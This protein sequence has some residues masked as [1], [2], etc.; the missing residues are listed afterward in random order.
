MNSTITYTPSGDNDAQDSAAANYFGSGYQIVKSQAIVGTNATSRT[1]QQLSGLVPGE[2]VPTGLAAQLLAAVNPL[3][4]EGSYTV[5]NTEVPVASALGIV[6]NLTG[7]NQ[8]TWATMNA[9]VQEIEDNLDTGRTTFKFGPAEHLTIHDLI[10]QIRA[11][12]VNLSTG[13]IQQRLTGSPSDSASV[14]GDG[15]HAIHNT[16]GSGGASYPWIGNKAN[17]DGSWEVLMGAG[18]ISGVTAP[19]DIA[20]LDFKIGNAG[21]NTNTLEIEC[22]ASALGIDLADAGG[23]EIQLSVVDGAPIINVTAKDASS[24]SLDKNSVSATDNGTGGSFNVDASQT[25]GGA[26]SFVKLANGAYVLAT[27]VFP[28]MPNLTGGATAAAPLF[29]EP[30]RCHDRMGAGPHRPAAERPWNRRLRAI[31]ERRL[32]WLRD[33]QPMDRHRPVR[34]KLIYAWIRM[35]IRRQYRHLPRLHKIAAADEP[36]PLPAIAPR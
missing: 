18:A 30:G 17:D 29:R 20:E 3:Q 8:D 21:S 2:P 31:V 10:E 9:L 34:R 27:E 36:R 12:R 22:T 7:S 4:Y 1:Y 25:G 5:V 26:A 11:L 35:A 19:D 15:T 13:A 32:G 24:S 14:D 23:D 28:V 16:D 6:L 33:V